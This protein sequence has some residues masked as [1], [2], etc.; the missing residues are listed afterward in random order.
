MLSA[1]QR[2]DLRESMTRRLAELRRLIDDEASF[3]EGQRADGRARDVG[4]YGDEAV[5]A[6]LA[7]TEGALIGIHRAEAREIEAALARLSAGTY[8]SCIGCDDPIGIERLRANPAARRC[9]PCQRR[10]E[11]AA[12]AA[13]RGAR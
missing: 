13:G 10:Y 2:Q 7:R 6:D 3:E 1:T 5:G 11:A 4:D 9:E 12:A 8:G